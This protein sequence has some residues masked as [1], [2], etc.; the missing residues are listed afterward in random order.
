MKYLKTFERKVMNTAEVGDYVICHINE[1]D[2]EEQKYTDEFL[3]NNIGILDNIDD[4]YQN[5]QGWYVQFDKAP[6]KDAKSYHN[7]EL[8]KSF[9]FKLKIAAFYDDE[10]KYWAKTEED[11]KMMK[12]IKN[13]NL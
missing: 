1:T 8:S 10:I 6:S 9:D 3:D 4:T 7:S 11:V 13:Y 5:S 12:D 2:P